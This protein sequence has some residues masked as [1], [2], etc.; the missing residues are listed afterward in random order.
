MKAKVLKIAALVLWILQLVVQIALT[1]AVYGLHMLPGK[2][3]L[4]LAVILLALWIGGGL[5]LLLPGKEKLWR[6]I[7]AAVLSA[8]LIAGCIAG[9]FATAKWHET[10]DAI[11][12]IPVTEHTVAVY[13]LAEKPAVELK[14]GKNFTYGILEGYQSQQINFALDEMEAQ[15]GCAVTVRSFAAVPELIDSLYE[16]KIDAI[17]IHG[18]YFQILEEN[19]VYLDFEEKCRVIHVVELPETTFPE[20][21]EPTTEPTTEPATQPTTEPVAEPTT[22]PTTEATTEPTEPE[23]APYIEPFVVYLSGS[24]TRSEYLTVSRSDVNILLVV[25]PQTKQILL[26]NTP[27]DFYVENP[28]GN[29]AKDK[30]THCGIYGVDCSV[31]ALEKFYG[32]DID[33]YA[34]LNFTGFE[35][36]INA[37][38]GI[39]VY[40]DQAF[41]TYH[42]G[43][44]I[45]KG[46]NEMHG[47]QALCYIRERYAFL[48]GDNERGRNQ[49]KVLRAVIDKLSVGN[50]VKNY[51]A[52]MDS[53]QGMFTT[54]MTAEEIALLVKMQLADN[55]G[56][57]VVTYAVWGSGAKE[58]TYS[59]PGYN[60]YVIHPNEKTVEEGIRLINAVLSGE[61]ITQ[62]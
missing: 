48:T 46:D 18:A 20:A 42:G 34:Q 47:H 57:N 37:L 35:T 33:Y 2:Y 15:L 4:L 8:L 59:M 45:E 36:M 51:G 3:I 22:E 29:W 5:L 10:M 30:L 17:V 55:T 16:G 38:G 60:L 52:I 50:L 31:K 9:C 7:T 58:V 61:T 19:E 62:N 32:V 56:W 14:D 44:I 49:M 28:A 54:D 13:V 26:L 40:S 23:P 43:Y 21:T 24:D 41:T 53:L 6:Q 39:T 27:R 25:N 1:V 11:T 12:S